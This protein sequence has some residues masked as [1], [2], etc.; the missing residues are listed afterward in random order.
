MR[1]EKKVIYVASTKRESKGNIYYNV[2]V[3]DLESGEI[4]TL[5]CDENATGGL[6]KYTP[7]ICVFMY[8][9]FRGDGRIRVA[10]FRRCEAEKQDAKKV[11]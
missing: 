6:T 5:S 8:S 9:E 4:F 3:E 11:S 10:G 7:Y 1:F 2:T